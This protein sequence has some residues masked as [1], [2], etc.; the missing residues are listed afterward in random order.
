MYRSPTIHLFS[1]AIKPFG[2]CILTLVNI[3]LVQLTRS[4]H[5][6]ISLH[7]TSADFATVFNYRTAHSS[8]LC[9]HCNPPSNLKAGHQLTMWATV[10]LWH[11]YT[12]LMWLGLIT[13]THLMWLGL[14][15]YTHPMWLGLITYTHLMWLGLITYT[16]LMWL[17]LI[18]YTHPMW[19]GLITYTHLMWLGLIYAGCLDV[20]LDQTENSSTVTKSCAVGW[21]PVTG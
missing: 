12:H 20:D 13:Y 9:C 6:C 10:R 15:T 14:I 21:N 1:S 7:I 17:G 4:V 8:A 19:L 2:I 3:L 18:T 5:I 16:H 11:T